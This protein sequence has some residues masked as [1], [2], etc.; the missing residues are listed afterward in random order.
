VSTAVVTAESGA[1]A[2]FCTWRRM[3]TARFGSGQGAA[4]N[5]RRKFLATAVRGL[6]GLFALLL[7]CPARGCLH[8]DLPTE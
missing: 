3:S 7:G 6:L 2:A 1:G 8:L 5:C 4:R